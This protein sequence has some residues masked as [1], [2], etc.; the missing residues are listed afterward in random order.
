MYLFERLIGLIIYVFFLFLICNGILHTGKIDNH[1]L[2]KIYVIILAIMGYFFVPHAG[3]DLSRLIL[4]MHYYANKSLSELVSSVTSSSTPGMCVYF[5]VIGRLGNDKLLPCISAL[6]TF[7]LCFD[8]FHHQIEEAKVKRAYIATALF[9]FMSRGLMMQII[10]NIRT[11]M[12]LAICGWCIYHEF[13]NHKKWKNLIVPYIL[14]A[15]LHLMGQAMLVYRLAYLLI[16]KGKNPTQKIL[17]TSAAVGV[18]SL[19][20]IFGNRYITSF[21]T[22]ADGYFNSARQNEGYSYFWEGLLCVYVLVILVYMIISFRKAKDNVQDSVSNGDM[23]IIAT[24]RLIRYILPLI[25]LDI[26]SG[27]VEF[28]FFQRTNWFL[29]ILMIPLCVQ[30]LKIA[31]SNGTE[32]TICNNIR[33][34]SFAMLALACARGDLCSL[35]FFIF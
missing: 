26:I 31:E 29:S 8:A 13:Y 34:A 28:N 21:L 10:S 15:S 24:I 32:K 19:I 22:K 18:A 7:S 14:A 25:V 33:I 6:I 23:S 1:R 30:L 9:L 16:E 5:F 11:I 12:S 4:T 17:R 2:L 20:W 35:K 3:A 27:F